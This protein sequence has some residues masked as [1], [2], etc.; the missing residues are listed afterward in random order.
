MSEKTLAE[1]IITIIQDQQNQIPTPT[2]ATIIKTNTNQ[3]V[4]IKT[5]KY[6]ILQYVPYY[7]N[8]PEPNNTGILIFLNGDP[9]QHVIIC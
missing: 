8:T 7:G 6:G 2:L 1:E 4:N 9:E 3:T 5:E